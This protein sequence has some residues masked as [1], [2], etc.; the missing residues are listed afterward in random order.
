MNGKGA[1]HEQIRKTFLNSN[2]EDRLTEFNRLKNVDKS[3]KT[4][5]HMFKSEA[6]TITTASYELAWLIAKNKKPFTD[7]DY[8]K[9]VVSNIVK[10]LTSTNNTFARKLLKT[11]EKIPAD[12]T[13][14]SNR[15]TE[16]TSE[17]DNYL[18]DM[19]S[20]CSYF[21]IA[22]DESPDINDRCKLIIC[23]RIVFSDLSTKEEMLTLTSL[24]N[25]KT[26]KEIYEEFK[27][28]ADIYELDFNKL[29]GITTDGAPSMI[30]K[31]EGFLGHVFKN[32]KLKNFVAAIHCFVHQEN[33]I[34]KLFDTDK[35]KT[36]RLLMEQVSS[37]CKYILSHDVHRFFPKFLE[38]MK[39]EGEVVEFDDLKLYCA[40]RW[41]SRADV[42]NRVASLLPHISNFLKQR[43]KFNEFNYIETDVWIN[44]LF[45][46]CD[47]VS[48]FAKLN[49]CLQGKNQDLYFFYITIN[50]FLKTFK[51]KIVEFENG[52][53]LSKSF[54][55]LSTRTG[56]DKS[57]YSQW[58]NKLVKKYENSFIELSK[59]YPII[60][61][62]E[63]PFSEQFEDVLF[64]NKV[65]SLFKEN[66][67]NFE[68]EFDTF[69][70]DENLRQ[71]FKTENNKFNCWKQV[72]SKKIFPQMINS[73]LK[74]NSLF[75]ST[76]ICESIFSVLHS[77]HNKSRSRLETNINKQL[78]CAL[79]KYNPN[80]NNIVNKY[81]KQFH[82]S[83]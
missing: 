3:A 8:I 38:A 61:F 34:P 20:T 13:T 48:I 82:P 23:I 42:L 6:E 79:T 56:W 72:Q 14:I 47:T 28:Q 24:E 80:F 21:S 60:L 5:T 44:N 41:L 69:R 10:T 32:F 49:K 55:M 27:A 16:L 52:F 66:S 17:V 12:R 37:L 51:R 7:G 68:S 2:K 18:K 1:N 35:D 57:Y 15:I 26:G 64:Y 9:Q 65:I 67:D 11:I 30:G 40:V 59:L 25:R 73:I 43:E 33:L 83:H 75:S 36:F 63:N 77:M 54:P 53:N 31:N 46:L 74:L 76:Y 58:L 78:K 29:V 71:L 45:F 81:R 39:G 22:L 62:Y 4:I 50:G 19:I 70:G